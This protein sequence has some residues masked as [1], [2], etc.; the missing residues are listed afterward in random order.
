[1][2]TECARGRPKGEWKT[3]KISGAAGKRK[4]PFGF[5]QGRLS[6]SLGMTTVKRV[7]LE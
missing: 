5:A 7:G 4:V 6:T 1:L 3:G 2:N